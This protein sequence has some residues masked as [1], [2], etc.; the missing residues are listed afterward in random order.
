[1]SII[2][3]TA[4]V[5]GSDTPALQA[6]DVQPQH[7]RVGRDGHPGLDSTLAHDRRGAQ[8][9]DHPGAGRIEAAD[10]QLLVD[11]WDELLD[12]AGSD[13]RHGLDSPR[14]RR[15]DP[16]CELLHSL[17]GPRD[18]DPA[19]LDEHV[20]VLVLAH[21]L[22]RQRGHLLGVI[23]RE[24]EIRGMAGRAAG[25]WQRTLVEQRQLAHA[26][27]G[28]VIGDA[29]ADDPGADHDDALR[30]G[31]RLGPGPRLCLV[32]GGHKRDI[33]DAGQER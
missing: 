26:E 15:H 10:D 27:P 13:Q 33:S 1:M 18:L 6:L 7:L 21:T 8:R 12:L 5:S 29:V 14:L 30:A 22:E 17:L 9:V 20:Q 3:W 32:S 24:D 25:V 4:G 23:D 16:A 2:W 28:Q 11:E 19:G 31:P